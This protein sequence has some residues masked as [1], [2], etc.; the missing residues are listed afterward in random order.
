MNSSHVELRGIKQTNNQHKQGVCKRFRQNLGRDQNTDPPECIIIIP[1]LC[2]LPD[3]DPPTAEG[4]G[5]GGQT[6][7]Q[8]EAQGGKEEELTFLERRSIRPGGQ[9]VSL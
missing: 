4:R 1:R 8:G 6:P 5:Q 9:P 3:G 7:R 2:R